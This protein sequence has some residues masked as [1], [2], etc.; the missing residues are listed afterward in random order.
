M[1]IRAEAA[2]ITAATTESEEAAATVFQADLLAEAR[3]Y[4][5]SHVANIATC[6]ATAGTTAVVNLSP[7]TSDAAMERLDDLP[8]VSVG[9][10]AQV[11]AGSGGAKHS[12]AISAVYPTRTVTDGVLTSNTT[13][14]SED[15]NFVAADVGR[16]VTGTG[17]P[18]NTTIA[19]V[20]DENTVVMS[21]AAT[22]VAGG[23]SVTIS[24]GFAF[25]SNR[26]RAVTANDIVVIDG[27]YSP[28]SALS[29]TMTGTSPIATLTVESLT[30]QYQRTGSTGRL[31]VESNPYQG[32]SRWIQLSSVNDLPSLIARGQ[33]PS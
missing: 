32:S 2:L 33:L 15:A 19:S 16:V 8:T 21:A 25:G 30:F 6:I 18:A 13:L 23:V 20:T 1:T 22:A 3:E 10:A 17:I 4:W 26:A 12:T 14:E 28:I 24:P 11:R 27:L 5:I 29:W 7:L 31:S 9:T